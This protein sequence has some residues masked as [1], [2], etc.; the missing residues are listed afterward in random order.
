MTTSQTIDIHGPLKGEIEVP[1]DKSMTHR[2]IM[3]S[4]LAKGKSIIEQ[5]LLG[6]DCL[7]TI[8]IF[9]LLGVEIEIEE[10]RLIVNSPGYQHFNIPSN[11]IYWKFWYN[12]ALTCWSFKWIGHRVC[13]IWR[14]IDRKTTYGSYF[15][16]F[17]INECKY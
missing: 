15:K 5:P 13:L 9:K 16:T 3:L 17:K 1:G 12:N 4:S 10:H 11:V 14:Y 8:E 2:A 7:R 6:E